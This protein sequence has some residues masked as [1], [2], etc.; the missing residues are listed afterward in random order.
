MKDLSFIFNAHPKVI[1]DLYDKYQQDPNSVDSSWQLFFRGFDFSGNGNGAVSTGSAVASG[2]GTINSKEFQV[3]SIIRAYRNR[4]HL[5]SKTNPIRERVNRRP[6]LDL[7][8]FKL[9]DADLDT[10]FQAGNEV[11]L[12]G[13]TLREIMAHLEKVYCKHIG[14]EFMHMTERVQRRWLRTRIEALEPDTSYGLGVEKKKRIL[15]KLNGAVVF[16]DFLGKKYVGQKRFSLEGGETTIAAI[17]AIIN[18]AAEYGAVE[19]VIGMAHRGRLNVLANIMGKTYAQI[20][21]EFEGKSNFDLSLGD[22]DVK[23]HMGFSSMVETPSGKKVNLKLMPN[24]S[25]LESV[26]PIVQGFTR[27]KR[28]MIY[29][30]DPK[31]IFSICIHGDAAAVGQGVV[32]ETAQMSELPGYE[33]GGTVHYVINNQVGFTT[34]FTDGRSSHYCTAA[35][36]A[37]NV[38]VFHVNGDDPEAVI[39]AAELAVEFRNEFGVDVWIDM[40]CYRKHGH[41]EGDDPNFTQPE[42][43]DIIKKHKNP[44]EVYVDQMTSRGDVDKNLAAKMEKK[45]RD[46]LQERLDDVKEHDLPYE[47][48]EV[49]LAWKKLN[50][51]AN[52][53]KDF[54]NSPDT[55]ISREN[56]DAILRGL[57]H[58]PTD[59]NIVGK[60]K[61][62]IKGKKKLL[63]ANLID[64]AFAELMA[65]GSIL[66]DGG[67]VRMSGQDV[68]RGTFSH[69]HAIFF[70]DGTKKEYNRLNNVENVKGQ[71]RIYNSLL[72]E[73]A[74]MGFEYGYALASPD[75]LVVWEGQFG[76]FYNGAQ[77]IVDQYITAAE[78]KWQR[79]N[80]LVL[81]LPHGYE[82]Q[83]PEHSSGRVER[84]LQSCA[85][86]NI[87]V[88]NCTTPAS[89]FH[90]M[91]RQLAR[92]FRKPLVIMSPKSLLR[93][94]KVVSK[95]EEFETGNSFQEVLDDPTISASGNKKVKRLLLCSG[96]VYYD[97]AEKQEA[98]KRD[99]VAIVRLEQLYPMPI[100]HLEKI[101][102]KYSNAEI[103]WVQ[104][105][106]S[107]MGGWQYMNSFSA[108]GKNLRLISRKSSASP[109]TGFKKVHE[110][111]QAE[112]VDDAFNK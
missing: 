23:Y 104:E 47:Y 46:Y 5:R 110:D 102:K 103:I 38:P 105:E 67:D 10:V 21:S 86:F 6:N 41:N 97:L 22:G 9:T 72:S 2:D 42:M 96:K 43:Y 81:L 52:Q 108:L 60:V 99:D 53:P 91:R 55:G 49:E 66:Q 94:S 31:K 68:K 34:D 101:F 39:Y 69:R 87:T 111:K 51:Q 14:F 24:P 71:Y 112:I 107:N 64:W 48:Q 33:T 79:M 3:Y 35:A 25:H 78:S 92:P 83:G 89:F 16:E 74:V 100:N 44:R 18:K 8:D 98:D 62:L 30:D 56:I 26:D 106:S 12:P 59:I 13:A 15:E 50:K 85:E 82:G 28:D 77:T 7:A 58:I 45:F 95:I 88:A 19:T 57:M 90:L 11:G 80:G 4:G 73:F 54:E 37:I 40:V 61:R 63:D 109:A 27:A 36:N 65:Y 70:D 93:H 76:D 1:S 32:Y 29:G 20:F 17:D 75:N 84:F